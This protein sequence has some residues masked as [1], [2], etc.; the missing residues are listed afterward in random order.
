[1][2]W[3]RIVLADVEKVFRGIGDGVSFRKSGCVRI[4]KR[5]L[6]PQDNLPFYSL[7]EYSMFDC[8][9][10]YDSKCSRWAFVSVCVYISLCVLVCESNVVIT[11]ILLLPEGFTVQHT[12]NIFTKI[13]LTRYCDFNV[14]FIWQF[15][16]LKIVIRLDSWFFLISWLVIM[17]I[18]RD[19]L[20]ASRI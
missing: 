19:V 20:I 16:F 3:R 5:R 18:F 6:V 15:S 2:W 17:R 12:L 1:M 11:A 7:Y 4:C 10:R 8:Y 9:H 13:A 14:L